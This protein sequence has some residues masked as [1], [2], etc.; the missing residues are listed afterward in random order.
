MSET[1][2]ERLLNLIRLLDSSVHTSSLLPYD[3][4]EIPRWLSYA[5]SQIL[6]LTGEDEIVHASHTLEGYDVER[7][8][9]GSEPA[10]ASGIIRVV[11][12][13]WL[14]LC[15]FSTESVKTQ[16]LPL[17]Q[18]TT[19]SVTQVDNIMGSRAVTD[20]PNILQFEAVIAGSIHRFPAMASS[21]G[22]SQNAEVRKV[23][24]LLTEALNQS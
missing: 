22:A 17:S 24:K 18:T 5:A 10:V 7:V 8:L 2:R 15:D 19:V 4:D 14:V 16:V 9:R 12:A 21:G 20:W 3:E 13:K 23:L 11:T 1:Y 6:A